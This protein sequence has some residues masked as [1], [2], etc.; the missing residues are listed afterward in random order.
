MFVQLGSIGAALDPRWAAF[1]RSAPRHA[2]GPERLVNEDGE[3]RLVVTA[4][5]P[6]TGR[7]AVLHVAS[8]ALD[9]RKLEITPA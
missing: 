7:R 3:E 1:R 8:E 2:Y 5:D 6:D 9:V 4:W